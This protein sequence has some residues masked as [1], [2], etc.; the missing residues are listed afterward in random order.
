MI[1]NAADKVAKERRQRMCDVLNDD[2]R[3]I[4]LFYFSILCFLKW[5]MREVDLV[6]FCMYDSS[7]G[8]YLLG[9]L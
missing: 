8:I 5:G 1:V 7:N 3:C 6:L 2:M 4:L 9:R